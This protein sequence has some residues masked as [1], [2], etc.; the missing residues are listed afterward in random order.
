MAAATVRR[1][2]VAANGVV[3][4]LRSARASQAE[5]AAG[6]A[7][8]EPE[9]DEPDVDVLALEPVDDVLALE[10]VDDEDVELDDVVDEDEPEDVD[11]EPVLPDRASLR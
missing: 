4:R 7:D 8:A 9:P 2:R 11:A 6:A 10:P 1:L 3:S 5:A